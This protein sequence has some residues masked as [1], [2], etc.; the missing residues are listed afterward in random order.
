M[1]SQVL[2]VL[3]PYQMTRKLIPTMAEFLL[4]NIIRPYQTLTSTIIMVRYIYNQGTYDAVI[5]LN[6][7]ESVNAAGE[8]IFYFTNK[9]SGLTLSFSPNK[10]ASAGLSFK[11][12]EFSYIRAIA[13]PD[14]NGGISPVTNATITPISIPEPSTVGALF[15]LGATFLLQRKMTATHN[16]VHKC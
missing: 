9:Y 12:G 8:R 4:E 10:N 16:K 6:A 13:P 3:S 7:T 1:T 15:F 14:S 2:K 5:W 11:S